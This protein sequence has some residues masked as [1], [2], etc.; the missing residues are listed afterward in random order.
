MKSLFCMLFCLPAL[1]LFAET[2]SER[3]VSLLAAQ[4]DT[5]VIA[6][7][8]GWRFLVSEIRHLSLGVAW[9]APETP[10]EPA[11]ADPLPALRLLRDQLKELGIPLI[12]VPVPAKASVVPEGLPGDEAPDVPAPPPFTARL[13]EE[14]FH[15]VELQELLTVAK[16]DTQTYCRSDTHWS[17]RGAELAAEAVAARLRELAK[18][19]GLEKVDIQAD[20]PAP[21][22]IKGDLAEEGAEP[23]VLPARKVRR[24]D[25]GPLIDSAGPV[26]LLGD[27][28]TMAFG[29][30]GDMHAEASGFTEHLARELGFPI[31]RIANRGSASTPPRL[32]LFRSASRDPAWLESKRAVVYLFTERELTQSL[33]GWRE[34]PVSPRFR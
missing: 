14:G 13:R 17:P 12:I 30:G 18:F 4:P 21:I 5:R 32:T 9:I 34:L 20:D 3:A 33:N 26:L 16:A 31:D 19:G 29:E 27:S 15:T 2:L 25:G 28:H 22:S 11:Q 10:P 8:D 7:R 1:P 24:A 6:G 23:E